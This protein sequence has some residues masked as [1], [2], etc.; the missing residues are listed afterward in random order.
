MSIWTQ[1][2][3]KASFTCLWEAIC[4]RRYKCNVSRT[5]RGVTERNILLYRQILSL[6]LVSYSCL[7]VFSYM[8]TGDY[9][10]RDGEQIRRHGEAP[11]GVSMQNWKQQDVCVS[12]YRSLILLYRAGKGHE[13]VVKLDRFIGIFLGYIFLGRGLAH[14]CNT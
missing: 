3:A 5:W 6:F 1:Q 11:S 14:P 13:M 2:L 7:G 12:S 4:M 10:L 9:V 8:L